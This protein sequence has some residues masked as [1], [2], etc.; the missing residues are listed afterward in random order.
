M[1]CKTPFYFYTLSSKVVEL[2]TQTSALEKQIKETLSSLGKLTLQSSSTSGS[3]N[4]G[5]V[6]N[7]AT[8]LV[9]ELIDREN[10]KFN[11]VIRNLPETAEGGGEV[12]KNHFKPLCSTLDLNVPSFTVTRI[13][14]KIEGKSRVLLVRL[15]DL[16]TKRQILSKSVQLRSKTTWKKVYVN[17]DLTRSERVTQKLLRDELKAL[18]EKGESDLII[19]GNRIVKK[20][21]IKNVGQSPSSLHTT[22]S[23]CP[24]G[25]PMESDENNTSS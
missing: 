11:L 15:P 3:D 18:K 16:A 17:P 25:Q 23:T 8:N 5:I 4:S 19:R 2:S 1:F 14:K 6:P 9:D 24:S 7:V 20:R 12:D 10:R 22:A 13:G 21:G